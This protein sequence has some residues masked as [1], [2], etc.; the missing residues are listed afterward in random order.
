MK[1]LFFILIFILFPLV[2]NCFGP[3][4]CED[5]TEITSL[6]YTISTSNMCYQ[7]T[8]NLSSIGSGITFGA[9]N[10]VLLFGDGTD[11]IYYN[12]AG[13]NSNSGLILGN[14]AYNC[15]ISGI[16]I[17]SSNNASAAY[18]NV[19]ITIAGTHDVKITNC[20]IYTNGRSTHNLSPA[21]EGHSIQTTG[22][23]NYMIYLNHL[24]IDHEITYYDNR[25]WYT[26]AAVKMDSHFW[27][28]TS[29]YHVRI[30][31]STINTHGQGLALIGRYPETDPAKFIIEDCDIEV[32]MYSTAMGPGDCGTCYGTANSYA[33]LL[34][35]A[36]HGTLIKHCNITS[37]SIYYGGRGILL[38]EVLGT[39]DDW[40]TLCSNIV[41]IHEGWDCD[42]QFSDESHA[43]RVRGCIDGPSRLVDYI[44]VFDNQFISTADPSLT[45]SSY[46]L[47]SSSGRFS[48]CYDFNSII[49][50]NNLFRALRLS[51]GGEAY[52]LMFD[53]AF[54]GEENWIF[55]NNRVESD[56]YLV[57]FVGSNDGSE[58]IRL[59]GDTL[60][61][62]TPTYSP[63]ATWVI[64]SYE[65]NVYDAQ[66]LDVYY[67]DAN[68][69]T[70]IIS[71]IGA[72]GLGEVFLKEYFEVWPMGTNDYLVANC[73]VGVV[74]N[75]GQIVI[76]GSSGDEGKI[77]EYE[78]YWYESRTETD[79]TSF[80][81]FYIWA[82]YGEDSVGIFRDVEQNFVRCTVSLASTEGTI[83]PGSDPEINNISIGTIDTNDIDVICTH[84]NF[85][86]VDT[87]YAF[88]DLDNNIA[89]ADSVS[90]TTSLTSP[91][92][93][94][95]SGL[96]QNTLYWFWTVVCSD[97]GRDTSSA[98]SAT[99]L[100]ESS[101]AEGIRLSKQINSRGNI[102]YR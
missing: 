31:S 24:T 61:R 71:L 56:G 90:A 73:S 37:G 41:D 92:T 69:D 48:D 29:S 54:V 88:Y 27:A 9:V 95:V 67:E 91:K 36:G 97:E 21:I 19:G 66:A 47:S 100:E 89:G 5:T 77:G 50:E 13:S 98:V 79:S 78:T 3:T 40:V 51:S 102:K 93:I 44:H 7:I 63:Y 68:I 42:Y 80:N 15:T 14:N 59:I 72:T 16:N 30:D 4:E 60:N 99:T 8:G 34:K 101:E 12:T 49:V 84:L 74:N 23:I 58:K 35:R 85:T 26:G 33:I 70:N 46:S 81:P 39:S 18:G 1:K 86:N 65:Y 32:D 43:F 45:D 62:L 11:T 2:A 20:Y 6:P 28:T 25:C 10:N 38:E 22:G 55:Q 87:I 94:N 17:V 75:Y 64:A 82:K 76:L 53:W 52:A 96:T 57:S 83:E